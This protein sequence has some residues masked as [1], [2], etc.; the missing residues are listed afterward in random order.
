MM[1]E[2][3]EGGDDTDEDGVDRMWAS[4]TPVSGTWT[5]IDEE[6][7]LDGIED[8]MPKGWELHWAEGDAGGRGRVGWF[9]SRDCLMSA[10]LELD[11]VGQGTASVADVMA[12]HGFAEAAPGMPPAWEMSLS[13]GRVARVTVPREVEAHVRDG[14]GGMRLILHVSPDGLAPAWPDLPPRRV[15]DLA[16]AAAAAALACTLD[17]SYMGP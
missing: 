9:E 1:P 6:I 17:P 15:L 2:G 13:S 16:I 10:V 4:R 7:F 3:D 8:G 5:A 14:D 11:A 12:G